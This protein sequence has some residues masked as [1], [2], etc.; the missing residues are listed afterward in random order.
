MPA[1]FRLD[2]LSQTGVLARHPDR[3]Y[4]ELRPAEQATI[5]IPRS[6]GG[7]SAG[8]NAAATGPIASPVYDLLKRLDLQVIDLVPIG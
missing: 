3:P 1:V 4:D 8:Y 6:R 2:R 5:P 7:R